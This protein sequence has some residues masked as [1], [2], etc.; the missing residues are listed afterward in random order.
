[1]NPSFVLVFQHIAL[2]G[3]LPQDPRGPLTEL[4][5][6]EGIDPGDEDKKLGGA[7]SDQFFGTHLSIPHPWLLQKA[8]RE[9]KIQGR[10]NSL[11]VPENCFGNMQC[12]HN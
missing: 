5:G 6:P 1:M 11:H 8:V 2:D 9:Y 7:V 4:G 12:I 10:N 3:E